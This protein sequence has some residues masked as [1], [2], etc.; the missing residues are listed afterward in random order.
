MKL[1]FATAAL[2]LIA[3]AVSAQQAPPAGAAPRGVSKDPATAPSGTYQL[4]PRHTSIIARVG[5]A[6]GISFSTFRFGTASGSLN[7][8][9]ADPAASQVNVTV[10][11]TSIQTPVPDFAAELIGD[12]FLKTG[13]YH[14][15]KFVSTGIRRTGPTSGVISGTLTFM[16]QTKPVTIDAVMVG[17]GANR[18][19]PVIGFSGTMRFKRSD[20]GFSALVGPIS[21]EIEV[22][23][24]VEFDKTA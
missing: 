21:D 13:Q 20:F 5:H 3:P 12:R 10:D 9:N 23:L 15:A 7:W 8:N 17:N 22:V 4:D 2:L 19:G 24:D 11:M 6:G 14:D 1:A 18:N 16:G